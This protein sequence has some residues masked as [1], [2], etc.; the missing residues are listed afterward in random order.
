M[1]VI[2]APP[3]AV[4]LREPATNPYRSVGAWIFLAMIFM[5]GTLFGLWLPRLCQRGQRV[6]G[7][8]KI[9]AENTWAKIKTVG[10][11]IQCWANENSTMN[12][13]LLRGGTPKRGTHMNTEQTSPPWY[14]S[15]E[16]ED[17]EGTAKKSQQES[18]SPRN[19]S[20]PSQSAYPSRAEGSD[21][22]HPGRAEHER[23]RFRKT[24]EAM[25]T[26]A[27]PRK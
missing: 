25:I 11:I 20:G 3:Q 6:G 9:L 26:A 10:G 22:L 15:T 21:T 1:E 19:S 2:P 27:S 23:L 16:T 5:A 14:N 4:T 7:R 12:R 18:P 13:S 24:M 17:H 8:I